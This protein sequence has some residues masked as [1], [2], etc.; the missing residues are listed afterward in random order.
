MFCDFY[1]KVGFGLQPGQTDVVNFTTI[2]NTQ[3]S[4]TVNVPLKQGYR[5]F[6][7]VKCT[8]NVG[9]KSVSVSDGVLYD[10]TEPRNIFVRDGDYQSKTLTID[11]SAKFVDPESG[12][13]FLSVFVKS[14]TQLSEVQ[15][16]FYFAGNV[17]ALH[18]QLSRPL[19]NGAKYVLNVTATNGVG[20]SLSAISDGFS[21][22][23]TAP[24]CLYVRDGN[25]PLLKDLKYISQTSQ[26]S[27][28]W[29]C[30]DNESPILR[31]RFTVKNKKS[32]ETALPLH[33]L[34]GS[35][36]SSG[37]ALL[38]GNGKWTPNYQAGNSYVVGIE[39]TNAVKLTVLYW[40]DGVTVDNTPPSFKDVKLAFDP[41]RDALSAQWKVKT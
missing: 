6:A 18:V 2:P 30:Y 20:Q 4:F 29:N 10:E 31:Y 37:S 3:T 40:T 32:N 16:P 14:L 26:L 12:I 17:T 15:G 19:Q 1:F 41:V 8:N 21:V 33:S 39:L 22:D 34:K 7:S 28:S 36:N 27:V 35:L 25:S 9:L 5:Y 24:V 13:G 23:T 38:T 11:V